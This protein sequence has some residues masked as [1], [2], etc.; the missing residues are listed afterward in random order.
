METT[1]LAFHD[2]SRDGATVV[3]PS[4]HL[5]IST[6]H[7][8]RDHL[9]KVAT[10]EPRAVV[11]NLGALTIETPAPLSVFVS[12]QS[13]LAE[14][15]AVPLLLVP[16]DP[17][18]AETMVRGHLGRFVPVRLS[19]REA[20]AAIGDPPPR[21]VATARL[22]N[23]PTSP[24]VARECTRHTCA[25]WGVREV[26]DDA[27]LLASELVA[28]AVVHTS[29]DP[30]LRLEL[31]RGVFSVAVYDDEPGEVSVRDRGPGL[32]A[33]H[34]LLLVAQ[35][36]AAWGCSPTPDGGKVVWATVR[37]AGAGTVL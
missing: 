9:L 1:Q 30:R 24:R 16:G 34:G 11:V 25:E 33:V 29:C 4:G 37:T 8:L 27:V 14:W 31:R 22:T 17:D 6:C 32:T 18:V 21:R 3:T 20:I 5:D 19:V 12:V 7:L 13:R 36:A 28:N 26:S 35:V 15:P 2:Q 10:D 23:R